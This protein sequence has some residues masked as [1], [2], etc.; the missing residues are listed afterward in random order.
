M[1]ISENIEKEE[2][3]DIEI[4]IIKIIDKK[5]FVF[6]LTRHDKRT[7]IYICHEE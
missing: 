5:L 1:V 7:G 4:Y 6:F 3:L 2:K